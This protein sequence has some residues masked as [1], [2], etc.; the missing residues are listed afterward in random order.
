MMKLDISGNTIC[1]PQDNASL[2]RR[3]GQWKCG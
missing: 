1:D 3:D 2:S